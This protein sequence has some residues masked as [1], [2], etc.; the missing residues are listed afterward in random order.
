MRAKGSSQPTLI[1][2]SA[3]ILA[4]RRGDSSQAKDEVDRLIVEN[5]A[6]TAGIITLELLSGTRM[7]REYRELKEDLEALI[8]LEITAKTWEGAA[9]LAYKLKRKGVTVPSADVLIMA[10][11]VENGCS[12][13]HADRHFDLMAEQGIGLPPQGVRSLL[14]EAKAQLKARRAKLTG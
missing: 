5:L 7:A 10:I 6:A 1:D 9:H 13:L 8:Q 14:K 4:L 11:A 12:L 2:T 3:W